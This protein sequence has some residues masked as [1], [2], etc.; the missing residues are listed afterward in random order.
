MEKLGNSGSV[1]YPECDPRC[2]CWVLR[3]RRPPALSSLPQEPAPPRLTPEQAERLKR[4][5][6]QADR[7]E[8]SY[9]GSFADAA[10]EGAAGEGGNRG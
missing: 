6:E 8:V 10:Q 2:A 9:L 7:G 1:N 4:S 3:N 5:L